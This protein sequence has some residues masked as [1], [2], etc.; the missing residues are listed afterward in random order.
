MADQR[1]RHC[2]HQI[3]PPGYCFLLARRPVAHDLSQIGVGQHQ[4]VR[5]HGQRHGIDIPRQLQGDGMRQIACVAQA[6][7]QRRTHRRF[8]IP[9]E[10][11]DDIP[12]QR[13][14]GRREIGFAQR[15]GDLTGKLRPGIGRGFGQQ[16]GNIERRQRC[17]HEGPRIVGSRQFATDL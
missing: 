1:I 9:R 4:G 8:D 14:L 15:R 16:T 2:L 5:Q 7:R 10:T 12:R 17:G 3:R 13:C 6:L 11:A